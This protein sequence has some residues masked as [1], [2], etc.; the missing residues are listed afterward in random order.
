[1]P[2]PN[3]IVCMYVEPKS[4]LDYPHDFNCTEVNPLIIIICH[5][6]VI[7][8]LRIPV[9]ILNHTRTRYRFYIL[10]IK[11]RYGSTLMTEKFRHKLLMLYDFI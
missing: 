6:Y 2:V 4:L 8:M 5:I 3:V 11:R 7:G 9:R 1:M 10:K